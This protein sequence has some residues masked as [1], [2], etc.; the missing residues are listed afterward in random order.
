MTSPH[1]CSPSRGRRLAE[2]WTGHGGRRPADPDVSSGSR[3]TADGTWPWGRPVGD[4]VIVTMPA[5]DADERETGPLGSEAAP[6]GDPASQG[7]E[8]GPADGIAGP[9]YP[10]AGTEPD[11]H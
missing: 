11:A 1:G 6:P 8:P 5:D 2:D 3:G 4:T 10:P 7:G 9:S